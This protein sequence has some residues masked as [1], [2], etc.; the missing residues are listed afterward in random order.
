MEYLKL[1]N[2]CT[3][4]CLK[5]INLSIDEGEFVVIFGHSG[6]GKSTILNILAGFI[7]HK[8]YLYLKGKLINKTPT[9]KREIGYLDQSIHLFPHLNVFENI[10]FG[11]RARGMNPKDIK[12]S[13][14]EIAHM[15]MIDHLLDRYP[16]TLSGGEKQRVGLARSII[17][18]PKVLLLDEPLS[19]LD[20][21]TAGT[22][23][24]E[25]KKLHRALG[26]TVVYVTHNILDA[27][28]L[29]TKIVILEKGEIIKIY[30]KK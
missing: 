24:K 21:T 7:E 22:I 28:V 20:E 26:L 2:I 10:A 19:S 9:Q 25:L 4:F 3:D 11:L 16:K 29:A 6:A 8:G 14:K 5:N 17:T 18:K 23:R 15:T 30:D 12:R 27:E 13:V 1:E